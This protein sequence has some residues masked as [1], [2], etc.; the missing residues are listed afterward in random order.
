MDFIAKLSILHVSM[1]DSNTPTIFAILNG[2]EKYLLH[3]YLIV[4]S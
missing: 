4:L 1:T 2:H 3:S